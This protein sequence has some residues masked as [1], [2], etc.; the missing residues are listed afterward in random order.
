MKNILIFLVFIFSFNSFAER[1]VIIGRDTRTDREILSAGGDWAGNGGGIAEENILYAFVNLEKFI[2]ICL[3]TNLC[4]I[5]KKEAEILSNIKSALPEEIK[6][7]KIIQFISEAKHAGTFI[8]AG[9]MKI[10]KTGDNVGDTILINTDLLYSNTYGGGKRAL[11]IHE[12]VTLLIHELGHHH[13]NDNH[14]QLD[15]LGIKLSRL[16]TQMTDKASL[17]PHD[18]SIMALAMNSNIEKDYTQS[19]IYIDDKVIDA[20]TVL[21]KEVECPLIRG[22]D[23]SRKAYG[24]VYHNLYWEKIKKRRGTKTYKFKLR[25]SL[26]ILCDAEGG[27]KNQKMYQA[28]VSFKMKK[29]KKNGK[30]TWRFKEN[31]LK[32]NLIHDAWWMILKLPKLPIL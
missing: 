2:T 1:P 20:S 24:A 23:I 17:F 15:Y 3:N 22:I 31:S 9:E 19:L 30:T 11:S 14:M 27:K 8:I 5:N 29:I 16:L 6:N 21:K 13:N 28:S 26:T 12:A 10:A 7:K 25:G 4:K 18:N 32:A